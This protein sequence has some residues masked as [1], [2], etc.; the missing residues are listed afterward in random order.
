M[1][2]RVSRK[3][4]YGA[5]LLPVTKQDLDGIKAIV[6]KNNFQ[7]PTLKLSV[8]KNRRGSYKGVYLWCKAN[9]GTCRVEPMFCTDYNYNLV[10]VNDV[11]I[12]V[13]E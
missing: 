7:N 1:K 12:N 9:L 4:D 13:E 8:Y 10:Q 6:V 5:I 11:K 2:V 3:I